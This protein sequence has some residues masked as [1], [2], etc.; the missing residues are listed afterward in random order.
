LVRIMDEK[1][2]HTLKVDREFKNLIR[3]LY[4]KEFQQLEANLIADGCID[5]IITWRGY[6]IDGH[7]RYEICTRNKIP[8]A[9]YEMEFDSREEVI[10]WICVN[11]LGR[12]NIS[13]EN[14]KYLIGK[15]YE[16]E[17][18]VD[19]NRNPR[20]RNQ[21]TVARSQDDL[22]SAGDRD[23]G[24]KKVSLQT[25]AQRIADENHISQGTVLK[26]AIYARA[27]ESI[28]EKEPEI[29]PKI[30]S[31]RVKVSHENIVEMSKLSTDEIRK[32]NKRMETNDAPYVQYKKMR[33]AMHVPVEN[34]VVSGPTVKDMPVYDPDA[35]ISGLTLTIPSWVG[36][37]ER[38]QAN[39]DL[40][41]ISRRARLDL[42]RALTMLQNKVGAML[43]AIK[44]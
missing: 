1:K 13:D 18:I 9:V 31:G 14:R 15:Q 21:Y 12:R 26:Y 11:Q 17:K 23:R 10:I 3:P 24:D 22:F 16:M 8:F 39:S 6:I 34:G 32:I 4:K 27:L 20:G 41:K 40:S 25:T 33:K 42:E 7:N 2:V 5:P 19:H 37:I 29:Y 30:L 36:S 38:I 35:E 44:E 28:K 43:L